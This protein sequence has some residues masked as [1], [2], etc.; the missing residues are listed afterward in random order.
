MEERKLPETD[1]YYSA[2][3]VVREGFLGDWVRSRKSFIDLLKLDSSKE[4][5]KPIIIKGEKYIRYRVKGQ[6]ILNVMKMIEEGTL[7][8]Q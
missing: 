7:N 2:G 6:H 8:T 5:F 1:K 4:L 3:A